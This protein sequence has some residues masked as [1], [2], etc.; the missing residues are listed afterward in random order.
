MGT[1]A[2][3]DFSFRPLSGSRCPVTLTPQKLAAPVG[4]ERARGR[5]HGCAGACVFRQTLPSE[6]HNSSNRH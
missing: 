4:A 1:P 5:V 3:S 2:R 6:K